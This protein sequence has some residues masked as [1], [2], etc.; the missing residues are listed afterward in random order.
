MEDISVAAAPNAPY[1]TPAQVP[2]A[3]TALDP[4]PNGNAIP[5]LF[6]PLQIR[7]LRLHN[8]ILVGRS[9]PDLVFP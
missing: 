3:G 8:R 1:F 6:H 7:G 2:P 4:Q 5:E 9:L